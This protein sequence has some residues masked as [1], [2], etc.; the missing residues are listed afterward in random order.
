MLIKSLIKPLIK[1]API[2]SLIASGGG[3]FPAAPISSVAPNSIFQWDANLPASYPGSGQPLY[4]VIDVPFG[5]DP[6]DN[7]HWQLGNTSNPT[8]DDPTFV[9]GIFPTAAKFTTDGADVLTIVAASTPFID[10]LHRSDTG[11]TFWAISAFSSGTTDVAQNIYGN[12]NGSALSGW[13][14]D[15][16]TSNL[17]R[18]IRSDGTVNAP[19]QAMETGLL[20]NT[21]YL[22]VFTYNPATGTWKSAI[23]SRTFNNTATDPFPNTVTATGRFSAFASNNSSARMSAGSEFY[24]AALGAGDLNNTQLSAIVDYYNTLHGRVY[25]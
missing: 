7:T 1:G 5:G 14:V 2:S 4:N 19:S 25:A 18:F 9:P 21:P 15:W 16:N 20:A 12:A 10:S 23:N 22:H 17:L 24:G 8:T 3:S 13:R 11:Q 6:H